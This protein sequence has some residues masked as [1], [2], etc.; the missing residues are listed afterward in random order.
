MNNNDQS[1]ANH[2]NSRASNID[3]DSNMVAPIDT[4]NELNDVVVT[5]S[6]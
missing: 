3:N 2:K 4:N 1:N 5:N 6:D